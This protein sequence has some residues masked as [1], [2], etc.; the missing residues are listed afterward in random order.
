MDKTIK[1]IL[2]GIIIGIII[3]CILFLFGLYEFEDS[4]HVACLPNI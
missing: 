3:S 4:L 2:I 1:G